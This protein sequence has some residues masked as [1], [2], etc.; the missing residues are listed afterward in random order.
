MYMYITLYHHLVLV[1]YPFFVGQITIYNHLFPSFSNISATSQQKNLL[2]CLRV[3]ISH[4]KQW[5]CWQSQDRNKIGVINEKCTSY[6]YTYMSVLCIHCSQHD[7]NRLRK[8]KSLHRPLRQY[9]YDISNMN[10]I[11]YIYVYNIIYLQYIYIYIV[12]LN[13]NSEFKIQEIRGTQYPTKTMNLPILTD[14]IK[15]LKIGL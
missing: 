4:L 14:N 8:H 15:K 12:F 5:N 2:P 6:V 3:G 13:S 10:I 7:V 1:T 9:P 11:L